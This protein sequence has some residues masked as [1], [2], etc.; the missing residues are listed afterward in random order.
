M[1]SPYSFDM[2][3]LQDSKNLEDIFKLTQVATY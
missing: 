1:F 2:K 3:D